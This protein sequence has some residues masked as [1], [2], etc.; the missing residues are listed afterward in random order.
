ML[1]PDAILT[2]QFSDIVLFVL[3]LN[4]SHKGQIKQINKIVDFNKIESAAIVINDTP[5]NGYA[6]GYG[7]RK[8]YW[9]KGYGEFKS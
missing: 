8:K 5:L 7:A 4:Y 9:K 2:S 1:V 3:R 6:Y